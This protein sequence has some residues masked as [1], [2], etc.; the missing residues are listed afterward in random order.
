MSVV[1]VT[2]P[3]PIVSWE[4][5]KAHLRLDTSE[6][7]DYVEGLAAAATAWIDGPSGWLGRC[8]GV[9]R[10]EYR[11]DEP[12][13]P[14]IRLPYGPVLEV[15]EVRSGSEQV[16]IAHHTAEDTVCL[17]QPVSSS[18]PLRVSYWAGH[19]TRDPNDATKWITVAPPPIK[20]AIMM[21]VAQWHVT[22]ENAITGA[23]A[24]EMPFAVDALLQPNRVYR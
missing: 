14:V 19:G 7:Q 6:E 16:P 3:A 8:I 15:V 23:G 22:R 10:L 11:V 2:P 17:G 21:L 5:L 24:S 1:V 4:E 12:C 18:L 13:S 20:V 9:Q